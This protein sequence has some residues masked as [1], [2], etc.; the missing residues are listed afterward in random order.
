VPLDGDP[1]SRRGGVTNRVIVKVYQAFLPMIL[2]PGDIFMHDGV[3]VHTAH[4]MTA[5]LR[6][7]GVIVMVWPPYSPDLNPIENL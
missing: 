7:M 3:S 5:I 1:E 6:E 2:E 4:I